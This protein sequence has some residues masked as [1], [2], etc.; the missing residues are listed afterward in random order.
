MRS[1]L[2]D[3]FAALQDATSWLGLSEFCSAHRH[4]VPHERT[5]RRWHRRLGSSLVVSPR[6]AIDALGLSH[7]HAF[8]TQPEPGWECLPYIIEYAWVTMDCTNRIL[9][10]HCVVPCQHEGFLLRRLRDFARAVDAFPCC[11]GWERMVSHVS[12]VMPLLTLRAP[13]DSALLGDLPVVVPAIFESWDRT[14]GLDETWRRIKDRLGNGVRSYLPG[15]RYYPTNG[16]LH[17]KEA[18]DRLSQEG[19]FVQHAVRYTPTPQESINAIIVVDRVAASRFVESV[20]RECS[21]IAAHPGPDGCLL[22]LSGG[23][24]L[25]DAILGAGRHP[26]YWIDRVGTASC[27][28]RVRFAYDQLFHPGLGEWVMPEVR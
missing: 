6:F 7:I 12:D 21:S 28:A 2:H 5:V 23:V 24:G 18:F 4:V 1:G 13:V 26:V 27:P 17:V 16:K 9:Y 25:F 14:L 11:T 10:L 8:L 3:Y 22:R 19:L 20:R 15:Q